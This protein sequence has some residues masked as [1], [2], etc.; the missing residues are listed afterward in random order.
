MPR[1]DSAENVWVPST[2]TPE[3]RT[4]EVP[5]STATHCVS[6]ARPYSRRL[7][8]AGVRNAAVPALGSVLAQKPD[9]PA[10]HLDPIGRED[11]GFVSRI[12]GLEG[13]GIAAPAQAL[14]RCFLV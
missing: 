7:A 14:E 2:A 13:D 5:Q 8:A 10:L 1:S 3:A 11:A 4:F 6:T 9:Q 12:G